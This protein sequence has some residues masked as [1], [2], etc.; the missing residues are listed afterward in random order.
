M[1]KILSVLLIILTKIAFAQSISVKD[2]DAIVVKQK[3]LKSL[4]G[5][6]YR[7][8]ERKIPFY[9]ISGGA[10]YNQNG[11]IHVT[12][13]TFRNNKT[14][15]ILQVSVREIDSIKHIIS[16]EIRYTAPKPVIQEMEKSFRENGY[17]YKKRKKQY[18]RKKIRKEYQMITMR[19]NCLYV[20]EFDQQPEIVFTTHKNLP[21]STK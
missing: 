17:R 8:I 2:F 7:F 1:K 15:E 12:A 20:S 19:A 6:A 10:P 13:E 5:D 21:K 4:S 11:N 16:V 14:Q 18:I 9:S 3:H